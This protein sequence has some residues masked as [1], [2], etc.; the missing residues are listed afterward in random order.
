M[1]KKHNPKKLTQKRTNR[2][3]NDIQVVFVTG[4]NG[5]KIMRRSSG[6]IYQKATNDLV[7]TI[8]NRRFEW[9]VYCAVLYRD[10]EGNIGTY[11][12]EIYFLGAVT[13]YDISKYITDELQIIYESCDKEHSIGVAWIAVPRTVQI[14]E[15]YA[16]NI[17]HRLGGFDNLALWQK[18]S[19]IQNE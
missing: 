9:T 12:H 14:D 6:V 1:A 7:D 3:L 10:Q 8:L 16:F 5:N 13:Q 11:A 4:L 2:Y 15:E 17:F 18:K 19:R